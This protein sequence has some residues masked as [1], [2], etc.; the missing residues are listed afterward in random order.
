ML[1][2]TSV[3]ALILL[4]EHQTAMDQLDGLRRY[5]TYD[6]VHQMK[7][8]RDQVR[9]KQRVRHVLQVVLRE[10]LSA[11]H[12]ASQVHKP[13]LH[14]HLHQLLS[15]A[16]SRVVRHKVPGDGVVC[17]FPIQRIWRHS[18]Q[19]SRVVHV[20]AVREHQPVTLN[21]R[22]YRRTGQVLQQHVR[23]VVAIKWVATLLVF[24]AATEAVDDEMYFRISRRKLL[25]ELIDY[26]AQV[27]LVCFRLHLRIHKEE[28]QYDVGSVSRSVVLR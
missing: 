16:V 9:R 15:L 17:R 14:E 7:I 10:Q 22:G 19:P 8:T 2:V 21:G 13:A 28:T 12:D 6:F 1:P 20:I 23:R 4:M 27:L 3:V 18:I 26:M 5:Q 25:V 11:Y 24:A